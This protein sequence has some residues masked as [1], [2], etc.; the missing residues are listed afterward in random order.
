M[1]NRGLFF[2]QCDC[3]TSFC[4][5]IEQR[6]PKS[7]WMITLAPSAASDAFALRGSSDSRR[8]WNWWHVISTSSSRKWARKWVAFSE[9]SLKDNFSSVRVGPPRPHTA[10]HAHTATRLWLDCITARVTITDMRAIS[11]LLYAIG[12][13]TAIYWRTPTPPHQSVT[14]DHESLGN[15][16]TRVKCF[17]VHTTKRS[18]LN[19]SATRSHRTQSPDT[20]DTQ[21]GIIGHTVRSHRTHSPV[22]SGEQIEHT[23]RSRAANRSGTQ[24]SRIRQ[25]HSPD[26]S[27][28]QSEHLGHTVRTPRTHSPVT[29]DT[30]PGHIGRTGHIGHKVRSHHPLS[31]DTSDTQSG[32]TTPSPVS[33]GR[34]ATA[35]AAG[36]VGRV[37][38]L[39]PWAAVYHDEVAAVHVLAEG[40]ESL[41]RSCRCRAGP[42]LA[43]VT[44][45]HGLQADPLTGWRRP[46]ALRSGTLSGRRGLKAPDSGALSGRRGLGPRCRWQRAG[47]Q[48]W[49]RPSFPC[50]ERRALLCAAHSQLRWRHASQLRWRHIFPR[51]ALLGLCRGAGLSI[52]RRETC[53]SRGDCRHIRH[54]AEVPRHTHR[55]HRRKMVL[56][57]TSL[58]L[59]VSFFLVLATRPAPQSTSNYPHPPRISYGLPVTRMS[60]RR[61]FPFSRGLID[62]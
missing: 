15:R 1:R 2:V 9:I 4:C 19:L 18:R 14:D 32:H 23:V 48:R 47:S 11:W 31:P 62:K 29:S 12:G 25:T 17:T 40:T 22:T 7:V 26:T 37:H 51:S 21:F 50:A 49:S 6:S 35:A 24:I 41:D 5:S 13:A 20:S 43:P 42:V 36:L 52:G 45:R 16:L 44:G 58:T 39:P 28:T 8:M 56:P 46:P 10:A 53:G 59:E 27:D 55:A 30:Q 38:R 61:K 33:G 34:R 60:P 57:T 3:I 54:C